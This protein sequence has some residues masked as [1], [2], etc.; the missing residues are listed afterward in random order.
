MS[1]VNDAVSVSTRDLL[2]AAQLGALLKPKG[3]VRPIAVGEV[4]YRL[5]LGLMCKTTISTVKEALG[6]RQFGAPGVKGGT[7]AVPKIVDTLLR[8][9]P[10]FVVLSIDLSNAFNTVHRSAILKAVKENCCP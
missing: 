1:A 5:A 6:N 10:E 7:E 2:M 9:N 4:F 3:K 8:E